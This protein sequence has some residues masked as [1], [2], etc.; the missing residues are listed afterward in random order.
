M[1][2]FLEEVGRTPYKS[3][4][5]ITEGSAGEFITG[6]VNR[7]HWAMVEHCVASV[8]FI[9]DRGFSHECVRHRIASFCL[10]GDTTVV[11]YRNPKASART[12]KNW[13]LRQLYRWQD[14]VKRKGRLRLIRLRSVDNAGRI[15]PGKI[16]RVTLS[17][18]QDTYT[19]TSK[20]GHVVRA[21]AAHRFKTPSGWRKLKELSPG[22]RIIANGLSALDNA[23]WLRDKYITQNNTLKEMAVLCGCGVSFVTKALRRHGINKPLSMRKN[24]QPGRGVKGMFSKEALDRMSTAKRGDKNPVWKGD[25]VSITGGYSRANRNFTPDNCWGCSTPEKVERHHIDGNPRNNEAANLMYL[26]PKCHKSFHLGQGVLTVF[27][28]EILSIELYGEEQTYDLE[29]VDTPHNFVAEGYVVHNSQESTRFVNY[30]KARHGNSINIIELP[31]VK[32]MTDE[33][34]EY[35]QHCAGIMEEMY[36]T[37]E[38]MAKEAGIKKPAQIARMW[39]PIGIKTEI[40]MTANLREWN[41]V[42]GLRA[43]T[44]AHPIMK[45]LATEV[46]KAFYAKIPTVYGPIYRWLTPAEQLTIEERNKAH[47]EIMSKIQKLQKRDAR[48]LKAGLDD[49]V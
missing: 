47:A 18:V 9:A 45:G 23:E 36:F 48:L 6:L 42:F 38:R 12:Q 20:S 41:T 32:G 49:D 25:A 44:P 22:D 43:D 8:R 37:A 40:V 31:D 13:T 46:L 21:T 4:E 16:K 34:R 7:G 30:T 33:I 14:D 10:S 27:N 2:H 3:E 1:E 15:V 29:M 5:R 28:D 26:C 39:L 11:A 35:W 19:V 24:R 17:G